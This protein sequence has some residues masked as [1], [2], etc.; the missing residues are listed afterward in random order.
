[1]LFLCSELLIFFLLL[2]IAL[3][4]YFFDYFHDYLFVTEEFYKT[5]LEQYTILLRKRAVQNFA[6][7][8]IS[9]Y[10]VGLSREK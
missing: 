1:M 10:R 9:L 8:V 7:T 2:L 4:F 3:S 6:C 5:T